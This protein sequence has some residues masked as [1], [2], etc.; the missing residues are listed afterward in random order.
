MPRTGIYTF[1]CE[2][3]DGSRLTIDDQEVV[4]ND[5]LHGPVEK[6]GLIALQAGIHAIRVDFFERSGGSD[7]NV[8][9]QGPDLEK[10][11]LGEGL[12]FYGE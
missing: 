12:L 9:V 7:I 8:S 5:G 11:E 4:L 6:E 3:D 1:Y 10:Q 2:S